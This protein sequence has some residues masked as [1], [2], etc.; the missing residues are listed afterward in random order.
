MTPSK[1]H[2]SDFFEDLR[3]SVRTISNPAEERRRTGYEKSPSITTARGLSVFGLFAFAARLAINWPSAN[4]TVLC[5]QLQR[6]LCS[7]V[8]S[9]LCNRGVNMGRSPGLI[10][11]L[12]FCEI[13]G[14]YR[15]LN[16]KQKMFRKIYIVQ[17]TA[18]P[19]NSTAI[20][21]PMAVGDWGKA[22]KMKR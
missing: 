16:W 12:A 4:P 20:Y 6:H 21:H 17:N 1:H 11:V 18:T 8:Y 13:C 15:N 22:T 3:L 7:Q 5:I 10:R 19:K 14:L 2:Q 9:Q